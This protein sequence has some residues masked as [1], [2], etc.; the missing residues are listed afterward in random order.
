MKKPNITAGNWS[1]KATAGN[2]D[3]AIYPEETGK[4]IALVRDFNEANAQVI[5]A[6]P[7]L[8]D[9]LEQA[10]NALLYLAQEAEVRA[11]VPKPIIG[12]ARHHAVQAREALIAAGYTIP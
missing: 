12:G 2:H 8:L 5:A 9:A 4:D 3:F 11:G 7:K 1:Y 6:L 10:H